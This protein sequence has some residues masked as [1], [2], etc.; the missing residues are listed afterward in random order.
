[1]TTEKIVLVLDSS[2]LDTF[3]TC[4]THWHYQ[5]QEGL[6]PEKA[7][8]TTPM[9]MGTYGHKLMEIYYKGIANGLNPVDVMNQALEFD[10]DKE[11]CQCSH[12]RE[13]HADKGYEPL[14]A[15]GLI[16][17]CQTIGCTCQNFEGVQ[18]PINAG[19][20]QQVKDRFVE[21]LMV[22]G[23]SIPALRPH[24]PE[25]VEVGFSKKIYEDDERLYI[26][27]GRIDLIGQIA[28]NV[29]D[30]WADHKWQIR[31]RD[32]YLSTI[33][34][35]N[36]SMVLEK[37]IGVVNYVRLAKKFEPGK[38][39]KRDVISFSR[40]QI[41]WWEA[42]VIEMFN[43]VENAISSSLIESNFEKDWQWYQ[44]NDSLR[45]RSACS[46]RYGY[47]CPYTPI[48]EN[49]GNTQF[50][51]LIETTDFKKKPVWRPW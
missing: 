34:F 32:L 43:R 27:E 11:T 15:E 37:E 28:N 16:N 49:A 10:I 9:D 18:F 36:Y 14:V 4:P 41:K 46:G 51:K 25:H 26:L 1:M 38:T 12:N 22:E 13:K 45:R 8:P 39:F 5:Y 23:T 33:Q 31:E 7:R 21:Y 6:L 30:G 3:D 29:P 44:E 47:P 50:I 42:R 17:P 19:E 2:Q 20:R 35:R 24:S 48:C 40:T